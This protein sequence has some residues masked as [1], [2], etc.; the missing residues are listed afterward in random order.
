MAPG[1]K[2][3]TPPVLSP[4]Q[5]RPGWLCGLSMFHC[6]SYAVP[7]TSRE[8]HVISSQTTLPRKRTPSC[9]PCIG[10]LVVP[11]PA[12]YHRLLIQM[13]K[14]TCPACA[15][16][17]T[18]WPECAPHLRPTARVCPSPSS[19]PLSSHCL[20]VSCLDF[21]VFSDSWLRLSPLPSCSQQ[22]HLCVQ[23]SLSVLPPS[24]WC[25]LQFKELPCS[26]P[27]PAPSGG[28]LSMPLP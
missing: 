22:D 11:S 15:L 8:T 28:A 16:S 25:F 26:L 13:R 23:I 5:G 4:P 3:D 12:V 10:L 18:L 27:A 17:H 24:S 14:N 1:L 7:L 19:S 9:H 20:S 6:V 2:T 21:W